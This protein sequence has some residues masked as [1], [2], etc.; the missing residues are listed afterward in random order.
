MTGN[1]SVAWRCTGRTGREQN[2]VARTLMWTF[3]VIMLDEFRDG[4]TKRGF[5]EENHA[6]EAFFFDRPD[7][8]FGEGIEIRTAGWQG[9]R[10]DAGGAED[11]VEA[12]RELR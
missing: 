5:A 11:H 1:R 6:V 2:Y 10:F 4:M 8:P 3:L 7:E 12:W 9:N